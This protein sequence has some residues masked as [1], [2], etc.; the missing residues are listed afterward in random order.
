MTLLDTIATLPFWKAL[1]EI[2]TV[3]ILLSGTTQW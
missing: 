2:I 1:L 3:N